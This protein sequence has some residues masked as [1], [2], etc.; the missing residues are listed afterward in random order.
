MEHI[1]GIKFLFLLIR[2]QFHLRIQI[3]Q[4]LQGLL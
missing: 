4:I 3:T 2:K 1:D